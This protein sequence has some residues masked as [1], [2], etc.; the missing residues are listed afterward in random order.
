MCSN[1]ASRATNRA[2][3]ALSLLGSKR[4]AAIECMVDKRA[5]IGEVALP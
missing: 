1:R 2:S 5:V 4:A 3:R